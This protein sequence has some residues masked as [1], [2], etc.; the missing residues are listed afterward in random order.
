M[1]CLGVTISRPQAT[2]C[3]IESSA[4]CE[5]RYCESLDMGCNSVAK[6]QP[7]LSIWCGRPFLVC[8][9]S[10][11][12]DHPFWNPGSS[13]QDESAL[14]T[15]SPG[16]RARTLGKHSPSGL[17]LLLLPDQ[18]HCECY[19]DFGRSSCDDSPHWHE[20][21]CGKLQTH[22]QFHLAEARATLG[23]SSSQ[24]INRSINATLPPFFLKARLMATVPD[25][26]T[27]AAYYSDYACH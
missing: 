7:G 8:W 14:S 5:C 22:I 23:I 1:A 6:L 15:H 17:L 3:S 21:Y 24:S 11:N 19:A 13:N 20:H 12:S 2:I 26:F 27:G 4:L 18:H 16:D 9:G 25:V 10:N